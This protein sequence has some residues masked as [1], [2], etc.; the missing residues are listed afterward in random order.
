VSASSWTPPPE[1]PEPSLPPSERSKLREAVIDVISSLPANFTSKTFIEGLEAGDVFSLNS[2][3]G[4]TIEVQVVEALNQLRIA[5]DSDDAWNAYSF[6]RS[7]Q[8]FPD[9]RLAT[10]SAHPKPAV[11]PVALGIE[12]KGWYLLSKEKEPSFRYTVA[13]AACDPH[14]LLVIV[15]WYLSNVLSG[16]PV[17]LRPFVISALHA[18]QL[19]NHY[20]QVQRREGHLRD[21]KDHGEASYRVE[22]Q[23]GLAPYPPS[24]TRTGAKVTN[25]SG[26][27]FGRLARGGSLKKY[28]EKMLQ[29]DVVG[30]KAKHWV[31]FFAA[32]SDGVRAADL[33]EAIRKRLA[34]RLRDTLG[35]SDLT[36]LLTRWADSERPY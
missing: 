2:M 4:G 16:T 32:Y 19:R 30:I 29:T 20:W 35:D 11:G 33:D 24:K 9:V 27:N 10:D 22:D 13:S 36:Q 17:V 15:P 5:W 25:D 14:D 28:T 12:L 26:G 6:R 7:S 34:A 8:S 3:L 31:D 1:P 18:T 23:P 21:G